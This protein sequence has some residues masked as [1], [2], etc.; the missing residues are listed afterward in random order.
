MTFYRQIV[1]ENIDNIPRNI[2]FNL[3]R[4]DADHTE[5]YCSDHP[6]WGRNLEANTA[7]NKTKEDLDSFVNKNNLTK[8]NSHENSPNVICKIRVKKSDDRIDTSPYPDTVLF[9]GLEYTA[10]DITADSV[11]FDK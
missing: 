1:A 3:L 8:V 11:I 7:G 6:L 5:I 2:G 4:L 10:V 9:N